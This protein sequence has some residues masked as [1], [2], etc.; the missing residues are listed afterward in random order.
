MLV[1][2]QRKMAVL[3]EEI[4]GSSSDDD[5]IYT[6]LLEHTDELTTA[7]QAFLAGKKMRTQIDSERTQA[8]AAHY[9]QHKKRGYV[10]TAPAG[11]EQPPDRTTLL[12]KLSAGA[13]SCRERRQELSV[14]LVESASDNAIDE[15]ENLSRPTIAERALALACETLPQASVALLPFGAEGSAAVITNCERSAA[16]ALARLAISNVAKLGTLASDDEDDVAPVLSVG[17]ATLS[18]VPKNFDGAKMLES[19]AR[20][21]SAAKACDTSAVKSIEV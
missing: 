11:N 9:G 12:R 16:L 3:S 4:A 2:A 21:L 20:C 6:Q 5:A 10:G 15:C 17:V 14:L 7:M 13:K 18:V 19:A 1:D 8:H